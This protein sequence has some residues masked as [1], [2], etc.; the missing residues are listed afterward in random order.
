MTQ[1]HLQTPPTAGTTVTHRRYVD[2]SRAHYGGGL[3]DGG[4]VMG[5]F[6]DVATDLSLHTD[7]D[8][9]LLA[10][11]SRVDFHAPLRAGDVLEITA[12]LTRVGTRSRTVSFVANVLVRAG[13]DGSSS[14]GE[15]LVEPLPIASATGTVVVP[16]QG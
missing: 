13:G 11:Y 12:T 15:V 14:R 3:V 6:S 7:G 16:P 2:H 10:S 1:A 8:E 9:G 4:Y 5:L